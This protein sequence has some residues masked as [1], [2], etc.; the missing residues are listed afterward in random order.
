MEFS[1]T[2]SSNHL[3]L[4]INLKNKIKYINNKPKKND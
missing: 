2:D 4:S 1:E 3:H